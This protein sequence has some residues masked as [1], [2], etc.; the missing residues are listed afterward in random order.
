MYFLQA[1][2]TCDMLY[3]GAHAEVALPI[4]IRGITSLT[5]S[6]V[7]GSSARHYFYCGGS[8]VS[9][10]GPAPLYYTSIDPTW[11]LPSKGYSFAQCT[12]RHL[13][14]ACLDTYREST[15][16]WP[17]A[18]RARLFAASASAWSI[19]ESYV[20]S[21]LWCDQFCEI[22]SF[23]GL[24]R[25]TIVTERCT[26]C[27]GQQSSGSRRGRLCRPTQPRVLQFNYI[28]FTF[29]A[30]TA[31]GRRITSW[32]EATCSSG[33]AMVYSTNIHRRLGIEHKM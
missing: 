6:R 8:A 18:V 31:F 15:K 9:H 19:C 27:P 4:V 12:H 28:Q 5:C 24:K 26:T 14:L 30:N 13:F 16:W 17:S 2:R 33:R 10:S 3:N 20:E 11:F 23:A 21:L 22:H 32:N 29:F 1:Y 7:W 25:C